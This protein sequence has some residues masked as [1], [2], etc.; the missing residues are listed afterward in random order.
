M[1]LESDRATSSDAGQLSIFNHEFA[2]QPDGQAIASHGNMK[3]VPLTDRFI[4][5]FFRCDRSS[6][7][8]GLRCISS[9]AVNFTTAARSAP[10]IHLTFAAAAQ[11]DPTVPGIVNFDLDRLT[12]Q[13]V[14]S[15]LDVYQS[16]SSQSDRFLNR[17]TESPPPRYTLRPQRGLSMEVL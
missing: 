9:V 6:N 12:S 17:V 4:G 14:S 5:H 15:A 11:I 7:L 1:V 13:L 10:H 8:C 3:P 2:I 16:L